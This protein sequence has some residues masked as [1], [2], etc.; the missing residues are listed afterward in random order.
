MNDEAR[1][2]AK[3]IPESD[4]GTMQ[5]L[6]PPA[7]ADAEASG[8]HA[9][10]D[11]A[12]AMVTTADEVLRTTL[13]LERGGR[14]A[15]VYHRDEKRIARAFELAARALD[16]RV[17]RAALDPRADASNEAARGIDAVADAEASVIILPERPRP[18]TRL[19]DLVNYA[20][21]R[22]RALLFGIREETFGD[23]SPAEF[24]T[25]E[26]ASVSIVR[27][28]STGARLRLGGDSGA[29]L[30]AELTGP[31]R[32]TLE[33]GRARPDRPTTLLP[34]GFV[35]VQGLFVTGS[36]TARGGVALG[37]AP[38]VGT[39][40]PLELTITDGRVTAVSGL[41]ADHVNA[42]FDAHPA[43]RQVSHIGFG[44]NAR[45]A[46]EDGTMRD[47]RV[48]GVYLVLGAHPARPTW[49][50]PDAVHVLLRDVEIAID[51]Q[52]CAPLG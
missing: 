21:T 38:R 44:I 39:T 52:R 49:Q 45:I 11:V 19:F 42:Y 6:L 26:A 7:D 3:S 32:A 18:G 47:L 5:T 16:L 24:A 31:L 37:Q 14:L 8:A 28:L 30:D 34:A 4:L 51:G 29:A 9:R 23:V 46:A 25:L 1:S 10:L 17:F 27:A 33:T 40:A 41:D 35:E 2:P 50:S 43:T 15:L 36:C 13:G 22:K 12:A 48:P 20:P